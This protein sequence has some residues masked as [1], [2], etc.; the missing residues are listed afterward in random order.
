MTREDKRNAYL[1]CKFRDEQYALYDEYAKR[2]GLLMKSLLV[3]NALYYAKDGMTQK[4]ITDRTFQSKQTVNLIIKNLLKEGYVTV[5]ENPEN[6]RIK[7]V[8]LTEE[9]RNYAKEPVVHITWAEDTAMSML[10]PEEQE[11]LISLSRRFTENL[12]KLVNESG[13]ET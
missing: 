11:Q 7:F 12:T 10:T 13:D 2:N 8:K 5:E 3:L 9:G 4:E 6:K 1:Y